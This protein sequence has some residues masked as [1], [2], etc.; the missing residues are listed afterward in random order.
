MAQGGGIG[1]CRRAEVA[2]G[3]QART[4]GQRQATVQVK[5]AAN[6]CLA[7][8]A[9]EG[10][11]KTVG[12]RP[13]KVVRRTDRPELSA[14]RGCRREARL[15]ECI[16]RC[17]AF[18]REALARGRPWCSRG[19]ATPS[20]ASWHGQLYNWRCNSRSGALQPR[21]C[22]RTACARV[23]MCPPPARK[24]PWV[25]HRQ[26]EQRQL[27][28]AYAS[29]LAAL[30]AA[31]TSRQTNRPGTG[32][33]RAAS[34]GRARTC[35]ALHSHTI[36]RE[37]EIQQETLVYKHWGAPRRTGCGFG[38]RVWTAVQRHGAMQS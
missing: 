4:N 27:L 1:A 18:S 31:P 24:R 17:P 34:P 2:S 8:A 19:Q 29:A 22:A 25:L 14:D 35:C 33:W 28:L 37:S 32:R 5:W 3:R 13:S 26:S 23:T 38:L 11:H 7:P 9:T 21:P 10:A 15:G 16:L 12:H 20:Q 36:A 6:G 30:A